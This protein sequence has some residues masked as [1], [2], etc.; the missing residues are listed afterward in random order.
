MEKHKL[1]SKRKKSCNIWIFEYVLEKS[2]TN[3]V[4]VL[5]VSIQRTPVIWVTYILFEEILVKTG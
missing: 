5:N 1:E 2:P 3:F 4:F